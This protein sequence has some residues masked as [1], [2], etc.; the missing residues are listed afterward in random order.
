[1]KGSASAG[2]STILS[3]LEQHLVVARYTV[4]VTTGVLAILLRWLL[5]PVLG[6]SGFYVTVYMAVVFSALVSGL[7]PSILSA[8]IGVLGVVYWFIDPRYSLS[9]TQRSNVHGIIGCILVCIV[10]IA[11]GEANR[12][13][14]L[15]LN[16]AHEDLERRVADRTAELS[17][18]LADLAEEASVRK[19][20]EERLRRLSVQLMAVQD[21]ERR[22]IARDLHDTTGQTLAA[23]KMTVASLGRAGLDV[24]G[25]AKF[26]D[27]LNALADAAS[28]EIRT[29]SY[30]LHPPLLDEAGFECAARWFVDGFAKRSRIDVQFTVSHEVGRLQ[31]TVDLVLFRVLQESLTNVHRHSGSSAVNI[32]LTLQGG[33]VVFQVSD[34]GHGFPEERVESFRQSTANVGVGIA[35]MRER[36]REVGGRFEMESCAS[37][38]TVAVRIPKSSAQRGAADTSHS[39]AVA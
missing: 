24:P 14:Q 18:A 21:D 33:E 16:E 10:L 8:V 37:G 35:G 19:E 36:V 1:M 34:N 15:S 6:H 25:L 29:T 23:I 9:V 7:G 4:G 13:K 17:Q 31:S 28:Q 32:D 22:R 3:P 5:E 27:D 11:L 39:I 20:G 26:M 2:S 12:S 30:L 38:T